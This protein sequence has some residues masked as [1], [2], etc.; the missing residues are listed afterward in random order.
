MSVSEQSSPEVGDKRKLLERL[1][2]S[3]AS[4]LAATDVPENAARVSPGE[5]CWSILQ[6]TEHLTMVEYG[7]MKRLREADANPNPPD[8]G[9]DFSD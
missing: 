4:Y 7:L 9:H 1:Q 8:R 5:G 3:L 6:I 2:G